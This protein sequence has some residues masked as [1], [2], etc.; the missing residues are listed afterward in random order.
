MNDYILSEVEE[1]LVEKFQRTKDPDI[2]VYFFNKLGNDVLNIIYSKINL[3]FTSIPFEREDLAGYVWKS[4]QKGLELYRKEKKNLWSVWINNSYFVAVREIQKYFKNNELI[5]NYAESW[6]QY[7]DSHCLI[8]RARSAVVFPKQSFKDS[9]DPIIE[10][11]SQHNKT[12]T[13]TDIKKLLYLKSFGYSEREIAKKMNVSRRYVS[14]MFKHVIRI[15]K[16]FLNTSN[17]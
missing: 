17:R 12:Y 11:V 13:K 1:K 2:A 3:K 7:Q 16:K 14:S 5:L 6:D 9:I 8:N 4:L 10:Y 15:S